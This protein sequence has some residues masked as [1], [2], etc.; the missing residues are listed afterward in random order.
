MSRP[1]FPRC[2]RDLFPKLA[3]KCESLAFVGLDDERLHAAIEAVPESVVAAAFCGVPLADLSVKE[4]GEI[5][6]AIVRVVDERRRPSAHFEAAQMLTEPSR[7]RASD[8]AW[9]RDGRRI[10]C[11][12]AQLSWERTQQVWKLQFRSVKLVLPGVREEAAFDELL[13]ALYTPRG[14]Y[15]YR[16]DLELGVSTAGKATS[17]GGHTISVYGPRRQGDWRIALDEYLLPKLDAQCEF[18]ALV[19]FEHGGVLLS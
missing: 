13:L 1:T 9:V 10:A 15:V 18:V 7:G 11:K 19:P 16:H 4:R 5:M 2:H 17:S 6:K 3:A 12:G 8:Y 14:I